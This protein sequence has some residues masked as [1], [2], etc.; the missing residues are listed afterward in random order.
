MKKGIL[1]LILMSLLMLTGLNA[2]VYKQWEKTV[3]GSINNEDYFTK[4]AVDDSGNVYLTGTIYNS[5]TGRDIIFRKY[6]SSGELVWQHD[7]S[8]VTP[9]GQD[10][11]VAIL[12]KDGYVY[13]TG[14]VESSLNVK[15]IIVMKRDA[16]TG[17]LVWS[18]TYNGTGNGNDHVSSLTLDNAGNIYICGMSRNNTTDFDILI[19]KYNN[20]GGFQWDF[21]GGQAGFDRGIDIKIDNSGNVFACGTDVFTNVFSKIVTM[22]FQPD[23]TQMMQEYIENGID[24]S[25]AASKIAI[26]AQ[27]NV[28]TA[29]Y[30]ETLNQG[31]NIALIKYNNAGIQQWVRYYNGTSNGNDAVRDMKIDPAGNIYMT[32]YSFS[33]VSNLD[34][35]TIKY[36]TAGSLLWAARYIG[37]YLAGDNVATGIALDDS[38]NVYI[39]GGSRESSTGSDIVTVKYN[40][41]GTL[42]WAMKQNGSVNTSYSENGRCIS[43]DNINN[44][45]VAGVNDASDGILIKYVQ[46]P[47]GI[48]FIGNEIPERFELMQNYP[49]P[50]NPAAKIVFSVPVNAHV[51]LAVYDMLGKEI[52]VPVN[53]VLKAGKYSYVFEGSQLASGTYFYRLSSEHFSEVKKMILLK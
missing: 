28:Y 38:A 39:T 8:S 31:L 2:Q 18:K 47:I 52:A 16:A 46:A 50:F 11:G 32:G 13:I 48:Q 23:G 7:Y 14:D 10:G 5:T 4:S 37:N 6:N 25:D 40:T 22:K 51:K 41:V 35:I 9:D 17:S 53:D 33:S 49:N 26:D 3:N 44:V 45:F 19:V 21:T 34:Y 29:G 1:S 42:L 27:G 12:Y 15:D 24:S 36:N 30:V 20:S 43:V